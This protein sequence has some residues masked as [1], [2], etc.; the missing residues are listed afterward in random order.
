M[1]YEDNDASSDKFLAQLF[2]IEYLINKHAD[3]HVIISGDLNVDFSRRCLITYLLTNFCK[4]LILTP[5]V[6]QANY[7]EDYS[8][9][10]NIITLDH[11]VESRFYST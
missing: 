1:P 3:C 6:Q 2:N 11:F 8:Y 10:F 7:Q 9:N 5:T 4:R